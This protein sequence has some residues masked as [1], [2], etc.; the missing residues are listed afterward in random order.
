MLRDEAV[1]TFVISTGA[2]AHTGA[3]SRSVQL[4]S[5]FQKTVV[6]SGENKCIK[7]K[8]KRAQQVCSFQ[9]IIASRNTLVDFY[10]TTLMSQAAKVA[11]FHSCKSSGAFELLGVYYVPIEVRKGCKVSYHPSSYL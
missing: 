1:F 5:C 9:H 8:K 4:P 10:V 7:S 6:L 3:V 11:S 2:T